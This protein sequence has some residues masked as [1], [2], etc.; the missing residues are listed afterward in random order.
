MHS[1]NRYVELSKYFNVSNI[2]FKRKKELKQINLSWKNNPNNHATFV[3]GVEQ[4][5]LTHLR[6]ILLLGQ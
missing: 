4:C 3:V 5:H 1:T 2:S 6:S